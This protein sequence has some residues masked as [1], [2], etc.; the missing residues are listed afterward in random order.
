METE[1][2]LKQM[3]T[4][5]KLTFLTGADT[6]NTVGFERLGIPQVRMS[7]GPYGLRKVE[8]SEDGK[9]HTVPAVCFPTASAVSATWNPDL[10]YRMGRALA[11]ECIDNGVNILLGPGANMKRSPL[12]GRN[13]EYYSEDPILA[14]R[15]GSAY[16]RG[17]QSRGIGASLKHFACNSQET[18]RLYSSSE[19]D[20]RTLREIYLKAYEIIVKEA[21]P[22][23]V[24]CAYNRLNGVHCSQNPYLLDEILRKE[25]GYQGTV[26][27]DW[28]AVHDR[29][30]A[31]KA[32]L[33]LDMPYSKDSLPALKRAYEAGEITDGEIN[34]AV[35]SLLNL[36]KKVEDAEP[37]RRQNPDTVQ[38]RLDLARKIAEEA[39]TLLKNEDGVLPIDEKKVRRV[40]VIGGCAEHPFIQGG[41]SACVSPVRA[42]APL[43]AL[44]S[45]LGDRVSYSK[46]YSYWGNSYRPDIFEIREALDTAA[47]AD[48]AVVFVGENSSVE[49]EGSD[50]VSIRLHPAFEKLIQQ[51]AKVNPNT[52]VVVQAGSAIDMSAWIHSV[53]GVV[54]SWYTGSC[55]AE[56]LADV[57]LGRVNPSG[58]LSET[59]PLSLE[60]T[61]AYGSYPS[62]PVSWYGEGVLM[63]YRYYDALDREVLF[64]F[65]YGLSYTS[66]EYSDLRLSS[67]RLEK[68]KPLSVSLR[69]K[70][71]GNR[72]GKET[73]QIY[74]SDPASTVRRPKKELK[75][76]QKVELKPREEK[77]VT[78]TLNG[79]DFAFYSP[80]YRRWVVEK[81]VFQILAGASSRDIRL[82]AEIT[83]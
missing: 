31:L 23:T 56:A 27:S 46:A 37:L 15:M 63:G 34:R 57:L 78:I 2:I 72:T 29:P 65:G 35:L 44:R 32:S 64:P 53:K 3:T 68:G 10:A 60:D 14:G 75:G 83:Y 11:G 48:A 39:V 4:D 77:T 17:L 13:F 28:G 59:F 8:K 9:E 40:A 61:P 43:D 73:V 26:I 18:D 74:V 20:D 50:R 25:W 70:N 81:G 45:A 5:E 41:G 62:T 21:K 30:A 33:E 38:E 58:K 79:D 12:C 16:V 22:W 42:D 54:F 1:K 55:G 6:W 67:P 7:D 47:G 69:V 52:I 36:V 82:S 80:V 49:T 66:F 76:F 51:V 24:M 19:M 71:T